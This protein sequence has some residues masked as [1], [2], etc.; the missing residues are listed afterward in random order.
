MMSSVLYKIDRNVP[1]PKML[2]RSGRDLSTRTATVMALRPGESFFLPKTTKQKGAATAK[3]LAASVSY[4]KKKH[5]ERKYIIRTV[6]ENRQSGARI[7]RKNDGQSQSKLKW[8]V[9]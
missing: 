1:L 3:E 7:W 4:V 5:P 6:T 8:N 9:R 2:D